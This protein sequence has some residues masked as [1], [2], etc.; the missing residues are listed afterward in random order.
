MSRYDFAAMKR[1]LQAGGVQVVT[2]PQLFPTPPDVAAR[3]VEYLDGWSGEAWE[4]I[5]ILE[6]SAGTGNLVAAILQ[7]WP[8][9]DLVAWEINHALAHRLMTT[10]GAAIRVMHGDFLTAATPEPFD[11]VIMNPPFERRAWVKHVRHAFGMLRD[12]G[13]LVT[14]IPQA[15][16]AREELETIGDVFDICA[17][18]DNT[19]SGTGV[20]TFMAVIDKR[21]G[22]T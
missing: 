4:T 15:P 12:G 6:P 7:E 2:A 17:L 5:R 10:H 13:R 16:G 3:M 21:E 19:F 1:S 8:E 14:I 9:A 11:A 20:R 22:A 18:P